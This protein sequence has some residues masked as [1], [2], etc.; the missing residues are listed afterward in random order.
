M[1]Q[2]KEQD[3]LVPQAADMK[4][5]GRGPLLI[6][7]I[8]AGLVL[9]IL[10]S[11]QLVD[12]DIGVNSANGMLG[13]NS[14]NSSITG[15][16]AG[17]IFSF[18]TGLAGTFTACNVAAFSALAPLMDDAPGLATRMRMAL[19]P[20]GW[21]SL[22]LIIV[23]GSYGAIG[24]S[25]GKQIPQLSTVPV[26]HMPQRVIQAMIVFG[27]IGVIFIY[28]GL[29]AAAIVP[30]PFRR[31]AARFPHLPQLVMGA[32]IGGFLI[33]RPYPLFFKTF[34]YAASTH[35]AFYGAASFILV[36]LGN[37]VIM[38][39]L[40]L[41]LSATQFANWLQA[42]PARVAKFSAASLL[43]GGSFTF[44]YWAVRL[45][46]RFGYGWFPHMPWH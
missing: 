8:F 4:L 2:A 5:S 45:P 9:A 1:T 17:I 10:W 42:K 46:A 33:G 19:R 27:V 24:A 31:A 41:A 12:D 14:V 32:L 18:I 21:L 34:E 25:L 37:V 7:S 36:A 20:L 29:A 39:I 30:D 38:A 13:Y 44:F 11:A 28:L 40:F 15:I 43:A 22:G 16:G 23:A 3:G 35:N 6:L 26:W